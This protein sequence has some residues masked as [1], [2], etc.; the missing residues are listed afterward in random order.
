MELGRALVFLRRDGAPLP[1]GC[2]GHVGW[3]FQDG[4]GIYHFGSTENDGGKPHVPALG[5]NGAWHDAGSLKD[6]LAAMRSRRYDAYKFANFRSA[7]PAAALAKIDEVES[8]G[9][10]AIGN[11]CLDHAYRVLKAY[12]QPDLP[13]RVNHPSPNDWFALYNGELHNLMER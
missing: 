9:Y 8:S 2:A 13:W 10:L 12:G 1:P 7:D 3:G 6:T 11:N 4:A 5:D